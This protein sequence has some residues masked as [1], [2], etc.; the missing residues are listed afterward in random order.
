MVN[1]SV[2]TFQSANQ[3]IAK[4]KHGRNDKNIEKEAVCEYKELY[5]FQKLIRNPS[6]RL[7]IVMKKVVLFL[8]K[9]YKEDRM[10]STA[11]WTITSM[12]K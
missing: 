2:T 1:E 11:L 6:R 3:I 8:V 5:V 4:F 7:T 12:K 9:W 10:Q